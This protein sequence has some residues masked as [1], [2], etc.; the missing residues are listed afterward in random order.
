MTA[1][2]PLFAEG[3]WRGPDPSAAVT[4]LPAILGVVHACLACERLDRGELA[5]FVAS[6][7]LSVLSFAAFVAVLAAA[8]ATH[9][10]WDA[11]FS[12]GV[13]LRRRRLYALARAASATSHELA[14]VDLGSAPCRYASS[15]CR[16]VRRVA[17]PGAWR[18][19][20]G[21]SVVCRA[22]VTYV[23][24]GSDSQTGDGATLR[25]RRVGRVSRAAGLGD[26]S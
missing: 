4:S 18:L 13:F 2:E 5:P 17:H 26:A 6:A 12:E 7:A 14:W 21:D 20:A 23:V 8:L 16:V 9:D 3:R 15:G 1:G 10:D 22:G 11:F 19:I 24:E 25:L